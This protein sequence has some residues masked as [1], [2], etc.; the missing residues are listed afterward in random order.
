MR[1]G[2]RHGTIPMGV[3]TAY[4]DGHVQWEKFD[5]LDQ[6]PNV[7]VAPE[8]RFVLTYYSEWYFRGGIEDVLAPGL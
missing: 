1:D 7:G 8:D 3:N 5:Q 2:G 6:N 4:V